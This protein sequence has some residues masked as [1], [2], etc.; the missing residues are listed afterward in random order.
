MLNAFGEAN[1]SLLLKM[2]DY[3]H[4]PVKLKSLIKDYYDNY[5][6]FI[7]TGNYSTEPIFVRKG[8]LQGDCLSQLLF[9]MFTN[10]LIKLFN[11]KRVKCMRYNYCDIM[12]PYHWF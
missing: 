2:L 5:A 6:T 9:N 8:G 1:H 10:T 12:S 4:V 7:G 11:D 3:H